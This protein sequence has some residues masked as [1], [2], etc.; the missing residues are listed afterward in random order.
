MKKICWNITTKCNKSCKYCF[1]CIDKYDLPIDENI[2]ILYKLKEM[3]IEKISWSGGEPTMY[4]G[5]EKLLQ[6]SKELNFKN[7]LVTNASLLSKENLDKY[8]PF[9]DE[10][11][12]SID[13]VDDNKNEM[14][15]R[16]KDYY[17]NVKEI[18]IA[19]N[20]NYTNCSVKINTVVM[21]KNMS[22][23]DDI[24]NEI[25][26]LKIIKWKFLQFSPLR[27]VAIENQKEFMVD[28][29]VFQ[30]IF[31]RFKNISSNFEIESHNY[32]FIKNRHM[33]ILPDGSII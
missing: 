3:N 30:Q 19:I 4:N 23:I 32:E 31:E 33:V 28:D 8:I 27:G 11:T 7:N 15:G 29:E 25:K 18:I 22:H 16:G 12:F 14:F 5:I 2:Q 10:I 24:Y 9:L 17:K 13:F 20:E 21:K 6:V 1:R 26:N